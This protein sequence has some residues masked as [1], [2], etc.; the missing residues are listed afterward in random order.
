MLG[1]QATTSQQDLKLSLRRN[2]PQAHRSHPRPTGSYI[3]QL[4]TRILPAK[5]DNGEEEEKATECRRAPG[6]TVVLLLR[7]RF[8]GPEASD[9]A[10]ESKTLQM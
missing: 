6:A 8:R 1:V 4:F 3:L 10:P 9:L 5:R 2:T 7:K